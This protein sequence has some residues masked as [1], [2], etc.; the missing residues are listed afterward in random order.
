[1]N[2]DTPV[3]ELQN[4]YI[5]AD[6]MG[7]HQG[8]AIAS[9]LAVDHVI[10]E[11]E[12]ATGSVASILEKSIRKA[13]GAIYA[14]SVEDGALFG[15]GTTIDVATVHQG[16]LYAGHVGDSRVYAMLDGEL[17]QLTKDHSYVQELL[18]ASA[19][20]EEEAYNHPNKNRITRALGVDKDV[21]VDIVTVDV[22]GYDSWMLLVC[23][24]GL[25]NMLRDGRILEIMNEDDKLK[26][27]CEKLMDI[28]LENGGTDNVTVVLAEQ[29]GRCDHA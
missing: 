18:D 29:K 23:S 16:I 3:G 10:L 27:R 6:G 20:T 8:G 13:N 28:S 22:S 19:I 24:D 17:K 9:K 7:G 25:T 26:Y 1:M 4:L 14:R 12:E 11:V 15:M 2:L 5:V 21:E